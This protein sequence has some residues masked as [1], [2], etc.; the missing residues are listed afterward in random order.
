[1]RE[2]FLLGRGDLFHAFVLEAS[3]L[4]EA[5]PGI[6]AV[7][8]VNAAL[9]RC[10]AS[11]DDVGTSVKLVFDTQEGAQ[12]EWHQ[13]GIN[14]S[15]RWPIGLIV[16][17]AAI[18][19]LNRVFSLFLRLKV[20]SARL[21]QAWATHCKSA[22]GRADVVLPHP[23]RQLARSSLVA[24]S[25]V[26]SRM[27]FLVD[28]MVYYLQVDVVDGEHRQ[29]LSDIRQSQDFEDAESSFKR[30]RLR[31]RPRADRVAVS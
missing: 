25:H 10:A 26:R 1:M 24:V 21:S 17:P 7:A 3:K 11:D 20:V 15:V 27:A 4:F 18:S 19:T 22:V 30:V 13:L 5:P 9:Q 12:R 6:A 28:N 29:L 2:Y 23:T 16:T 31:P 14:I 8:D